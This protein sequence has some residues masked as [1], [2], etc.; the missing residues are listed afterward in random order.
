M[1]MKNRIK[2]GIAALLSGTLMVGMAAGIIPGNAL[3]A[4]AEGEDSG[5]PGVAYYATKEQLMDGTFAPDADGKAK[6]IGKLKLGNYKSGKSWLSQTWYV[7]GKDSGVQGD[8]TVIFAVNPMVTSA[9]FNSDRKDRSYKAADG[10]YTGGNPATVSASHYGASGLRANLQEMAEP[11]YNSEEKAYFNKEQKKL[12]QKTTVTT[13][14]IKNNKDYTTSDDLYALNGTVGEK[15]ICA[16]SKDN[17]VLAADPYWKYDYSYE[18]F[19][20]RAAYNSNNNVPAVNVAMAKSSKVGYNNNVDS[21]YSSGRAIRPASNLNLSNVLFASAAPSNREYASPMNLKN[22]DTMVLRLDGKAEH[23]D[24]GTVEYNPSKGLIKAVKGTIGDPYGGGYG[25]QFGD[26]YG[27]SYYHVHVVVQGGDSTNP[28]SYAKYVSDSEYIDTAE[29]KSALAKQ[30]VDTGDIDLKN[31]HIWLETIGWFYGMTYAVEATETEDDLDSEITWADVDSIDA[32][33]AGEPLDT[34]AICV[35]TGISTVEPAITWTPDDTTAN[36]DTSYTASVTLATKNHYKFADSVNVW[37]NDEKAKVKKNADGTLKVTYTFPKTVSDTPTEPEHK[38]CFCGKE[39]RE[40]NGDIHNH[41]VNTTWEGISSLNEIR[42]EGC[43]YLK[44][45]ITLTSTWENTYQDVKLCL[46]G[47][48]I[49]GADQQS[50]IKNNNNAGL[51]ITDCHSGSEAGKI[52]HN[53]GATGNGI[54]NKSYLYMYN[55]CITGNTVNGGNGAGVY[56]EGTFYMSGGSITHNTA[57]KVGEYTGCGGGVYNEGDYTMFEMRGHAVIS[58]N[59]AEAG[60]GIY[61]YEQVSMHGSSAVKDN[62][63]VTGGGVWNGGSSEDALFAMSDNSSITGNQATNHYGGGVYTCDG[64]F[65]M[66][67]NASIADNK[68]LDGLGGGVYHSGKNFNMNG[69]SITGNTGGGGIF[70]NSAN[71][72]ELKG[73]VTIT[74]NTNRANKSA[75]YHQESD[76]LIIADGLTEGSMIGIEPQID[77]YPRK[78]PLVMTN[79]GCNPAYFSS[80]LSSCAIVVSGDAVALMAVEAPQIDTQPQDVSVKTG[81]QATFTVVA[82]GTDLIYQWQI[83]RKDGKGFVDIEGADRAEYTTGKVDKDCDGFEYCCKISNSRDSVIT[84]P[85]KLKVIK[86]IYTIEAKAGAAGRISP[87]GSV[88]ITEGESQTFTITANEGY[89]IESLK[90]DGTEVKIASGYTFENVTASHTIEA[91]FCTKAKDKLMSI[92]APNPITVANGTGYADMKLP[93]HVNIVTEQS[94]A[95]QAVVSWDTSLPMSGSYDPAV[96]AEQT[97]TLKGTVTCPDDL[98]ANGV[99]LTTSVTVTISAAGITGAP[100]A[101]VES[102]TYT[103]NQTIAL[104]ST[105]EGAKIYYTT[106]GSTPT[107]ENGMPAGTTVEYTAPISVSGI[108]GQSVATTITAI[109]VKE[110]MQNSEEKKFTYTI[111]IAKPTDPSDVKAP[112]INTQPQNVSVKAGEQA[113]FT[114]AASGTDLTYRWQVDRKDGNGFTDISGANSADYKTGVT[115]K[116]CDGFKYQCVISN[117]AGSVT[118]DTVTLTVTENATTPESVEYKIIDGADSTWTQNKDGSLA[119]RGDGE[120]AKFQSVK[121]DGAVIDAKNYTVTEGSTI[122]T[123]KEDYL[124]TL[125]AGSHTFEIVWTDGSAGTSLTVAQNTSGANDTGNKENTNNVNSNNTNT[126]ETNKNTD[127]AQA[128]ESKKKTTDTKEKTTESKKKTTDTKKKAADTKKKTTD[129]KK[130]TESKKTTDTKKSSQNASPST[131]DTMNLALLVT[132]LIVALAG[133]IGILGRW[134]HNFK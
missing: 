57:T 89:E 52:T 129:T 1:R 9:Q 65:Y 35:T 116:D 12:L 100:I 11:S 34:S 54:E 60:G 17:I 6:N 66:N 26:S 92:T 43:Y 16:G 42:Q 56:N 84:F 40:D 79:K 28:W 45:N 72:V 25:N 97:V 120:I 7:L 96:L 107:L 10:A 113:I 64:F 55:G 112:V 123:L 81:E 68:V 24:I 131:G 62:I 109:A 126:S 19:W 33:T 98:D 115:D 69:G 29:I 70:V 91:T 75:N 114:V 50:V 53:T 31:C 108:E 61:N 101:S 77:R 134:K 102:G 59:T 18:S 49:I 76:H 94:T 15:T 73:K 14:D 104:S 36:Y 3:R 121:V 32:P 47:Y 82:S 95:D 21:L 117:A 27:D 106:D 132:L 125:A 74:G 88:E 90:V 23:M 99:E 122:I 133:L 80:D 38:H 41:S 2:K 71:S 48:D 5:K 105:T 111:A 67:D 85:A 46:N 83:D 44:N 103:G 124:K 110:K 63:A 37:V 130:V 78:E 13:R 86:T 30:G 127:Q 4:Q 20:L 119:I 128:T 93:T 8:N 118:T 39:T 58:N 51:S 22:S 87:S